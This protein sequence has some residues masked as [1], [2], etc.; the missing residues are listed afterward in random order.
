MTEKT[1][2]RAIIALGALAVVYIIVLM[3]R[4]G[5]GDRSTAGALHEF[6]GLESGAMAGMSCN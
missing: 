1:L 3:T 6:E 5:S 4:S 2:K